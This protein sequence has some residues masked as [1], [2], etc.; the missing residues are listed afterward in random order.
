MSTTYTVDVTR[1]GRWWTVSIPAVD[2]VTQ[3]RRLSDV[4]S[5]A[6]ELVAVRGH[7]GIN[8]PAQQRLQIGQRKRLVIAGKFFLEREC[9]EQH[10]D[11]FDTFAL[12][13]VLCRRPRAGRGGERVEFILCELRG[14]LLIVQPAAQALGQFVIRGGVFRTNGERGGGLQRAAHDEGRKAERAPDHGRVVGGCGT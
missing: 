4:E 13:L 9:P 3:A 8:G 10:A 12:Q 5:M 11:G 14:E 2:G 1:D 7:D 6:R